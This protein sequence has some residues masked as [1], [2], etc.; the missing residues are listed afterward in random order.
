MSWEMQTA[1]SPNLSKLTIQDIDAE[2]LF[3]DFNKVVSISEQEEELE[4]PGIYRK[5]NF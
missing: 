3:N 5:L 2:E 4:V 1:E